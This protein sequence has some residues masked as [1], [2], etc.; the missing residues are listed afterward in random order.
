MK[1][2]DDKKN[3]I[4]LD[5]AKQELERL[6]K[7]IEEQEKIFK[8]FRDDVSS[9]RIVIDQRSLSAIEEENKEQLRQ[10]LERLKAQHKIIQKRLIIEEEQRIEIRKLSKV[11]AISTL[12]EGVSIAGLVEGD[13][14]QLE[15]IERNRSNLDQQQLSFLTNPRY[16]DDFRDSFS[17]EVERLYKMEIASKLLEGV[18]IVK[19]KEGDPYAQRAIIE[20]NISNLTASQSS[21]ATESNKRLNLSAELQSYNFEDILAREIERRFFLHNG[22]SELLNQVID[23]V[24]DDQVTLE[25]DRKEEYVSVEDGIEIKGWYTLAEEDEKYFS[26]DEKDS[27]GRES[28]GR[29]SEEEK[30]SLPTM[31]LETHPNAEPK[32]TGSA[33]QTKALQ[34]HSLGQIN[35]KTNPRRGL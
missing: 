26:D 35:G 9:G 1:G 34:L 31:E 2:G 7:E 14:T 27:E 29:E 15:V 23:N 10:Y 8:Q 16:I 28:E 24:I 22:V 30:S 13:P 12:L 21:L 5:R 19:L 32:T 25:S 33:A 6:K 17:A 4:T 3:K 20:Q 11:R 18:D